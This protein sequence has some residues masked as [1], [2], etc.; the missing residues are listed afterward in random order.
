MFC[1]GSNKNLNLGVG[2][3][4]DRHYPERIH[5]KRPDHLVHR[6][7][8]SSALMGEKPNSPV[9]KL[10][11]I[12]ALV[13]C[14]PLT[15]LDVAVSKLH[16]AVLTNDP[17]SNLYVCGIGR[18]GRLGLGDENTRFNFTPVQGGLADKRVTQVALG[19]NHTLAITQDGEL[20]TWGSNAFSQL[21]YALPP[22][23]KRDE[24]PMATTP[25]RVYGTLRNES[26]LGVAASSVHSVAHTG[27]SLFCWGKNLGQLALMDADSR[28]LD[29]QQAPRKVAASRF[30]SPIVMV[31]AIDKATTC[32]LA[33][34]SVCVFTSYGYNMIHFPTPN[35]FADHRLGTTS[36]PLRHDLGRSQVGY[37]ASGGETIAAIS[38]LGDLFTMSLS[39]NTE[40]SQL[41]SSTT[42]PS[43]IK[44]AVT[45]P[46]C[47]WSAKKDGIRSVDV[48]EHGSVVISTHSG[49]V[50]RRVKRAKAKDSHV[51]ESADSKAKN[52][53]FQRVPYITGVVAVRSSV[54]GAFAAVRK[55]SDVMRKQIHVGD[56]TIWD[57]VA[58]LL[59]LRGFQATEPSSRDKDTLKFWNADALEESLGPIAYQVLKSPDLDAD[60]EQHLTSWAYGHQALGAVVCTTSAPELKI[61]T[62]SWILAARSSILREGLVIS[63]KRGSFELPEVFNIETH[64]EGAVVTFYNVDLM[65]VLN[66]VLYM[67]EDKVIP[68]WNYAR[69]AP[70]LAYRYRKI[71]TELMKVA[72]R[73]GMVELEAASRTQTAPKPR[74]DKDFRLATKDRRFFEDGDAL[75]ELDGAEVPVHSAFLSQRCPFFKGLFHGRSQGQWLA[76]RRE[77][78]GSTDLVKIDLKH[79][80]PDA[81][82][83]V[84]QHMYADIG[85]E[86]FDPVVSSSVDDFTDLVL[87]TL[88]MANELMLDRLSQICQRT[89][90]R[91]VNTRNVAHLLNAV[92]PC[93]ITEF[94]DAGLEYLCLQMESMLENHLLDDLD[95]DLLLELDEVV[96]ENQAARFPVARS[97]RADLELH[98]AHPEL[99]QDIDEERHRRVRE[100]VFKHSQK[101]DERRTSSSFRGKLGS[102]D[103][104]TPTSP[105]KTKRKSKSGHNEPFS[106]DLRPKPS[107]ADLIFDMDEEES[108]LSSPL[109][110]PSKPPDRGP[111]HSRA[112]DPQTSSR[113]KAAVHSLG[114]LAPETPPTP[115][116]GPALALGQRRSTDHT[117]VRNPWAPAALAT[118]KLDLREI[119]TEATGTSALSTGLAAQK[120]KE[121]PL[122]VVST[123]L[124]QKERK[125]QQQLQ[126]EQAVH[127]AGTSPAAAGAA[128]EAAATS[129]K[130]KSAAWKVPP[131][132]P[133]SSV[134]EVLSESLQP[135][136]QP[137]A[138]RLAAHE[139]AKSLS[140]RTASPDTR[141][142]GQAR[143]PATAPVL[144]PS[145]S[146]SARTPASHRTLTP[147]ATASVSPATAPLVPH[148][149]TYIKPA[150]RAELPPGASMADIIGQQQREARSAREAVARRSLAE[151]QEE[152]EEQVFQEW[153]DAESRR[154]QE[155]AARRVARE[156]EREETGGGGGRG[157]GKG[158]GRR[159]RGGKAVGRGG[160]PAAAGAG[161][162][163]GA[164]RGV[165]DAG[166]GGSAA[167]GAAGGTRRGRGGGRPAS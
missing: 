68:A 164:G 16:S 84:L 56:Q 47:I 91:F 105:E 54:F 41:A 33:N 88:S 42:N 40:T 17:V 21:G 36:T 141:F 120:A 23:T 72:D 114:S 20:W 2:D 10:E 37:I 52:F 73:L 116:S 133:R 147:A 126:A 22:P 152:Q 14:H 71:R 92:S 3:A 64:D 65:T 25:H 6:F 151:I 35:P 154:T 67:Y 106:P 30:S 9:T 32:L 83:Y 97:H 125:R 28:S 155:E 18:G 159:G 163:R 15:I 5:L 130:S 162:G 167:E 93:V 100:M 46:Q 39:H 148:S 112:S 66:L 70:P 12:P 156:R 110:T 103:D 90:G 49:A 166:D 101:E 59:C 134:T 113:G 142:S 95:T 119:M 80:D 89:M 117:A 85:E 118:A 149:K 98:E 62:H 122:K 121:A 19:L 140:R 109:V 8:Q 146:S 102:F 50:W 143:G 161:R 43:K 157:E 38:T 63:R 150:P 76:S 153:W 44:G 11:D 160:G 34:H 99:A 77:A 96:R 81:F 58:P 51:D 1:F 137:D 13:Q 53:K 132:G 82:R 138:K 136:A 129:D 108:E 115:S 135:A 60:L 94:K 27:A 104:V 26:I 144:A 139:A 87:D 145:P 61:P 45:Q 74:M 107:Q 75:L 158:R 4:D 79:M 165:S 31:S 86:L 131:P 111:A 78:L 57:D 127:G 48:G 124:S 55:D 24:D 128:W 69:Q 7:Y 29:T 123:R